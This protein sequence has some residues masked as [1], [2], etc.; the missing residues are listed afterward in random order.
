[1][2]ALR[3]QASIFAVFFYTRRRVSQN[4][5]DYSFSRTIIKA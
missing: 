2:D 5:R 4:C 1:M 3:V